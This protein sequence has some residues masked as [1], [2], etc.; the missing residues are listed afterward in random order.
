MDCVDLA[1]FIQRVVFDRKFEIEKR[2]PGNI[3]Y[4]ATFLKRHIS[5]YL[6]GKTDD[7]QDGD[8]VLMKHRGRLCHVGILHIFKGKKYIVHTM[9]GFYSSVQHEFD[10]IKSYGLEVEGVYKW[11]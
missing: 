11:K 1:F 5:D 9:D 7:H 3:F 10:R 4:F 6:Q 8:C 2:E